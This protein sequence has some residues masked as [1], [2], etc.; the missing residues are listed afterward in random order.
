V[1][2]YILVD[3]LQRFEVRNWSVFNVQTVCSLQT[4]VTSL[5]NCTTSDHIKRWSQCPYM[6]VISFEEVPTSKPVKVVHPWNTFIT[7][8]KE[9]WNEGRRRWGQ[10]KISDTEQAFLC[11]KQNMDPWSVLP[12]DWLNIEERYVCVCACVCIN[13]PQYGQVDSVSN[14]GTGLSHLNISFRDLASPQL[15]VECHSW[16]RTGLQK[17]KLFPDIGRKLQ[18]V[19]FNCQLV[20][21]IKTKRCSLTPSWEIW[22]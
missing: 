3:T 11:G 14:P 2:P 18:N 19:Y 4:V 22:N 16:T 12:S 9:L 5:L 6:S 21:R 10:D 8:I 7:H 1:T 15:H 17:A 20:T 13:S